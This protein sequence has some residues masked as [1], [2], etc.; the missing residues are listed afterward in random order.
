MDEPGV[1]IHGRAD[2]ARSEELSPGAGLFAISVADALD[3]V[4][5]GD[6]K[7]SDFR[8]FLGRHEGLTTAMGE[9]CAV[10]CARPLM[11]KECRSLPTP[12]WHVSGK[13]SS[14]NASTHSHNLPHR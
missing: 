14:R 8:L 12:L 2:L 13:L 9:W 4:L 10:A 5:C 7:Q 11:L 6:A 3:A 1:C